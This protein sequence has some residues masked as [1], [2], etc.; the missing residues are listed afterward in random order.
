MTQTKQRFSSFEEY[1]DDDDGTDNVYELFNGELIE[2]PPE[3]GFNVGI[4]VFLLAQFLPLVGHLRVRPHGL[5][6]EVRGEP[7]NRF[8][9]LTIICEQHIEQLKRRNTIRLSMAP[10]LLVVEVVSPG[11]LQRDRDY[12]AKLGQYAAIAIPEYWIIDPETQEISVCNLLGGSYEVREFRGNDRIQPQLE[13][14][15][16]LQLTAEEILKAGD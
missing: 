10:P 7:R 1:L 14:L 3:P 11:D 9:D 12:V 16:S 6:L 2:V 15:Q 8:P 5:E 13:I 4:A